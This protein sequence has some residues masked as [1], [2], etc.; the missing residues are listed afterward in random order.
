MTSISKNVYIN[1]LVD[2]I[3]EYNNTY[4]STIQ[5]KIHYVNSSIFID[6]GVENNDKGTKY[7]VGDRVRISKYKNIFAKSYTPNW[8]EVFVN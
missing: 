2:I 7:K 5:M 3:N 6:F 1:N 8:T 4:H